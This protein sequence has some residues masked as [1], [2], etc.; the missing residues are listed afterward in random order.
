MRRRLDPDCL[1]PEIILDAIIPLAEAT[2]DL[3]RL[4]RHFAP[5]GIGNP[6]PVFAAKG[7][8]LAGPPRRV[9]GSHLKLVLRDNGHTLP[10]IGF[11]LGDRAEELGTGEAIVD[12]AFRLEENV[13]RDGLGRLRP[14][15]LQA[16]LLDVRL[17]R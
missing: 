16:R 5:Y 3:H 13:W 8:R 10:A 14:P 12:V 11:N 7:V 2:H 4:M 1:T 15:E 6:A 9:G 17:A